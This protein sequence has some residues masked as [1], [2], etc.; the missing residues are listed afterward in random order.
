[1]TLRGLHDLDPDMSAVVHQRLARLLVD[2]GKAK[3]ALAL[4][5]DERNPAM[6]DVKGDAQMFWVIVQGAAVL[7]EGLGPGRCR[8]SAASP[9][10]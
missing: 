8:R 4:L 3:E 7:P 5:D 1:M 2:G 10:D 9:A 6:L